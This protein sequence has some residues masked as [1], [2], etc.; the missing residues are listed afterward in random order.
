MSNDITT[1]KF[2]AVSI[3]YIVNPPPNTAAHETGRK[4]ALLENGGKGQSYITKEN[5][6]HI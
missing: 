1:L 3:I 4:T 6:G 2:S 5:H